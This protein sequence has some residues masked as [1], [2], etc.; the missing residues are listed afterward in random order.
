MRLFPVS[1]ALIAGANLVFSGPLPLTAREISLMLRSGYS[2]DAVLHELS[3]RH[4]V[5]TFTPAVEKQLTQS[6]ANASLLEAL[7]SGS[8]QSSPAETAAAR[9]KI[10]AQEEQA[11]ETRERSTK[12]IN[13]RKEEARS[14]SPATLQPINQV[15]KL[16]KGDLVW[17]HEGAVASYEDEALQQKKFY[18]FFFSANWSAAGRRFTPKLIE[19]Y[20]RVTAQHPE[21]EVIFFSADRSQFSME[22]YLGQSNMPW[23]AVAYPQINRKAAGMETNVIKE[24]PCLVLV[25]AGGRILSKTDGKTAGPE[26]VLADLDKILAGGAPSRMARSH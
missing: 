2:N 21:L 13:Q 7:R 4:F 16:L 18:L 14:K 24:I 6:G 5:D 17:W 23:P 26:K 20:N 25:D 11:A 8:Y 9:E 19:Y 3:A 10:A 15:Y 1:L 12:A 22:T